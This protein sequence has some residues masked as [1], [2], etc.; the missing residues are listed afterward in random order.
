[1]KT[2][3]KNI[4]AQFFVFTLLFVN[5]YACEQATKEQAPKE[6]KVDLQSE[7]L[8]KATLKKHR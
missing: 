2:S 6:D 7:A 4:L 5:F 8:F 3:T 1:M